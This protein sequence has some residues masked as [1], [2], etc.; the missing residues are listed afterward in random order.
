MVGTVSTFQV[1]L[2]I[3]LAGCGLSALLFWLE[4]LW[5]RKLRKEP[6]YPRPSGWLIIGR[7]VT[8]VVSFCSQVF[9]LVIGINFLIFAYY[10]Y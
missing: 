8:I 9:S 2:M 1:C 6:V 5:A 10:A 4:E 7:L 3:G